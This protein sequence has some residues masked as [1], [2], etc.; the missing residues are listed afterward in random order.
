MN[1]SQGSKQFIRKIIKNILHS[2]YQGERNS[3]L[4]LLPGTQIRIASLCCCSEL[5]RLRQSWIVWVPLPLVPILLLLPVLHP[6]LCTEDSD[7]L[8]VLETNLDQ[9][10]LEG[11]RTDAECIHQLHFLLISNS[12]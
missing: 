9:G 2:L 7:H 10:E 11:G 5:S 4:Q 3:S 12:P 8:L 1:C 6:S